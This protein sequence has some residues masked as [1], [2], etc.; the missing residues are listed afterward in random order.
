LRVQSGELAV[1]AEVQQVFVSFLQD[2]R[3]LAEAMPSSLAM[4]VNPTD[5]VFA[6]AAL[7][8]WLDSFFRTLHNAPIKGDG[9]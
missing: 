3:R 4:R 5:P 2:I 9:V 7:D 6:K 8:D 1:F